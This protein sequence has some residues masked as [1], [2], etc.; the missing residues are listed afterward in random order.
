MI[1]G[2]AII[3]VPTGIVTA[4][5]AYATHPPVSTQACPQCGVGGHQ[6]DARYCRQCGARL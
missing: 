5:I 6:Y 2:Y 4:E 1:T 3:A